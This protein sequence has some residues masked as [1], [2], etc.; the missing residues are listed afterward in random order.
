[1][2]DGVEVKSVGDAA[3]GGV[4]GWRV[5]GGGVGEEGTVVHMYTP[6]NPTTTNNFV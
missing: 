2:D 1:M 6:R 3:E 4:E 5:P